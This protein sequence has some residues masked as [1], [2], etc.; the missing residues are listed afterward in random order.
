MGKQTLEVS[1]SET[2]EANCKDNNCVELLQLIV[3]GEASP[4]QETYFKEHIEECV[5]C[6]NNF[7]VDSGMKQMIREKISSLAVPVGLQEAILSKIKES[8]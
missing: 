7:Q 4:E 2:K 3:D 5:S 1:V 6:F 8:V